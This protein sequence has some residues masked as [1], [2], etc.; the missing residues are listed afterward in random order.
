MNEQN[1]NDLFARIDFGIKRGVAQAL[2]EHK[3]SGQSI[4]VWKDGR[5]VKIPPEEIQIPENYLS[6]NIE[7]ENPSVQ[8][9]YSDEA[10]K[11]CEKESESLEAEIRSFFDRS[12]S[13]QS[14]QESWKKEKIQNKIIRLQNLNDFINHCDDNEFKSQIEE[15]L[16]YVQYLDLPKNEFIKNFQEGYRDKIFELIIAQFISKMPDFLLK[17]RSEKKE[18]ISDLE[19]IYQSQLYFLDCSTRDSNLLDQYHNLLPHFTKYLRVAKFLYDRHEEEQKQPYRLLSSIWYTPTIME[20]IWHSLSESE[21]LKLELVHLNYDNIIHELKNWIYINQYALLQF[22]KIIPHQLVKE[23]EIL[24]L[25]RHLCHSTEYLEIQRK[26]F[27]QCI[28]VKILDKIQKKYCSEDIPV[29]LAISVSTLPL[30]ETMMISDITDF[31]NYLK[32]HLRTTLMDLIKQKPSDLQSKLK[33]NMENLYAILIDSN[34]YDWF[35]EIAIQRHQANIP[36]SEKNQ[37][38][39]GIIYNV[40][41]TL[42]G[43]QIFNPFIKNYIELSLN[44]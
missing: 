21:K 34:W 17:T 24:K 5:V 29:I 28:A 30:I 13:G 6:E 1:E 42:Y 26:H 9:L 4:S 14:K 44:L 7:I 10:K 16:Q 38:R 3:K 2:A 18:E 15:I 23:I 39:R 43:N 32:N 25:P 41:H 35:P 40:D 22:P 20:K 37:C 33:K 11:S 36:N 12:Y 27:T 8:S 19:F 31:L